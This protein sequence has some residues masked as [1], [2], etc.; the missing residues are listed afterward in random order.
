VTPDTELV[1]ELSPMLRE[2]NNASSV[3]DPMKPYF[4]ANVEF[5][6]F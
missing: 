3:A 1:A 5:F 2:V 4:F 6:H